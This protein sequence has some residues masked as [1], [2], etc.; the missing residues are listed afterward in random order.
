[1]I[2]KSK[3]Y[4]LL[5]K[6]RAENYILTI[7]SLEENNKGKMDRFHSTNIFNTFL[8]KTSLPWR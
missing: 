5:S 8:S 2:K 6:G 1:M 4:K 7:K 3:I